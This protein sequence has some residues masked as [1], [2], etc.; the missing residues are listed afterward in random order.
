[1]KIS[2]IA[3]ITVL[4]ISL[5]ALAGPP[6]PCA[7]FPDT[8]SDGFTDPCDNCILVAN[9]SQADCDS[10]FCGNICDADFNQDGVT[11]IADFSSL[12]LVYGKPGCVQDIGAPDPPQPDGVIGIADF[13]RFATLYGKSPGPSGTTPGTT[14]CPKP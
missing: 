7:G 11:G 2:A 3:F 6:D 14:A 10:D 9:P 8:D 4:L 12:A 13:S 1:M 5:Q